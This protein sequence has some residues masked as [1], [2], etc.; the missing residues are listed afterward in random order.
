METESQ[1]LP[2]AAEIAQ[3]YIIDASTG[4]KKDFSTIKRGDKFRVF[5]PDNSPVEGGRI[6]TASSDAILHDGVWRIRMEKTEAEPIEVLEPEVQVL[7]EEQKPE[8]QSQEE[9]TRSIIEK[10]G[11]S[12]MQTCVR[13]ITRTI[14]AGELANIASEMAFH[15]Q[16]SARL[17]EEKKEVTARLKKQQDAHEGSARILADKYKSKEDTSDRVVI[18]AVDY[19]NQIRRIFD[20]ET[21]VEVGQEAMKPED[22]QEK[23]DLGGKPAKATPKAQE[24]AKKQPVEEGQVKP[25]GPLQLEHTPDKP[26]RHGLGEEEDHITSTA[27]NEALEGI[28]E[29]QE[30]TKTPSRLVIGVQE[31]K[32]VSVGGSAIGADI[33]DT[34]GRIFKVRGKATDVLDDILT[35]FDQVQYLQ[36]EAVEE[37]PG[38]FE[39]EALSMSDYDP[40]DTSG[41]ENQY[42]P[43]PGMTGLGN[44]EEG[45]DVDE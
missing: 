20:V 36:V 37:K 13:E 44:I 2:I 14:G 10:L 33:V 39:V 8:E 6:F 16:E 43:T 4:E 35:N 1:A 34:A 22:L 17:E 31:I 29:M 5:N 12:P 24:P 45:D 32:P 26:N 41:A 42:V 9:R 30:P 40:T 21:G 19:L 23:M 38:M 25:S 18:I 11:L 27:V 3:R 7:G 15:I 28:G